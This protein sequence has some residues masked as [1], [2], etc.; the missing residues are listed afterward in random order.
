M[1]Q[2]TVY[3][4]QDIQC[5]ESMDTAS[6]LEYWSTF[7]GNFAQFIQ[8]AVQQSRCDRFAVEHFRHSAGGYLFEEDLEVF[9][10]QLQDGTFEVLEN[11][12][13]IGRPL[14]D[15]LAEAEG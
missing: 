7:E 5:F 9:E 15:G 8:W 10:T 12:E 14:L 3:R 6:F 13:D 2:M 1:C 4:I 11:A